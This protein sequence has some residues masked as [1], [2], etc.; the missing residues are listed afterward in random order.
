MMGPVDPLRLLQALPDSVIVIDPDARL[1]G[2]NQRAEETIGWTTQELLGE[3]MDFLCHP[4]DLP[5]ALASLASVQQKAVGTPVVIRI[6]NR[7]GVYRSFEV[8]GRDAGDV[9][10]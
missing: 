4:D 3:P 5:T 2:A 1:I 6:R 7:A 8:I 9:P 10:G